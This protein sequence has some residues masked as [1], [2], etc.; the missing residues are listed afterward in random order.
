[1]KSVRRKA[2]SLVQPYRVNTPT[3]ADVETDWDILASGD[4]DAESAANPAS[5]FPVGLVETS[6]ETPTN[7][8]SFRQSSCGAK[9][10]SGALVFGKTYWD[11]DT[12]ID[13]GAYGS[14]DGALLF[15]SHVCF[16]FGMKGVR[17]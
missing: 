4:L 11:R 2:S 5:P 15:F 17:D 12:G 8:D 7:T 10:S 16:R 14:N 1:V 9:E 13:L 6:L 3:P